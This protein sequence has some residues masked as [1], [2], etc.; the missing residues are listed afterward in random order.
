M[1]IYI[2]IYY[3]NLSYVMFI[4]LYKLKQCFFVFFIQV[5][6]CVVFFI[7]GKV[8]KGKIFL[9]EEGKEFCLKQIVV[10]LNV[11][12]LVLLNELLLFKELVVNFEDDGFE[13]EEEDDVEDVLE[14]EEDE[15]DE[16]DLGDL[17]EE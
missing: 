6:D 16:D 4:R 9:L 10:G 12:L 2:Y 7:S 1:Y 3:W 8:I 15:G 17:Q 13:Q 11:F 5:L 14:G